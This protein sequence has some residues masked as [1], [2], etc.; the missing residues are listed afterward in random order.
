[1]I[2]RG[3]LNSALSPESIEEVVGCMGIS[4]QLSVSK[5]YGVYLANAATQALS[6]IATIRGN[7]QLGSVS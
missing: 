7:R 5:H 3:R 1:M 6:R 4:H 2:V